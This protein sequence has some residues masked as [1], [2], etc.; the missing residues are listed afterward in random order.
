MAL[1]IQGPSLG[2]VQKCGELNPVN[3]T[4][5]NLIPNDNTDNKQ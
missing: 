3:V 4:C 1:E 5:G 2:Q